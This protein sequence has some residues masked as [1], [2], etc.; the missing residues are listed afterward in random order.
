VDCVLHF[1]AC[2]DKGTR[3]NRLISTCLLALAVLQGVIPADHC[4]LKLAG[5]CCCE[6]KAKKS[7]DAP[8][9][10]HAKKMSESNSHSPDC[11]LHD[12]QRKPC[13]AYTPANGIEAAVQQLPAHDTHSDC[14]TSAYGA[15]AQTSSARATGFVIAPRGHDSPQPFDVPTYL[16]VH[17][18]LI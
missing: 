14:M 5:I 11:P 8:S 9:C 15:D 4:I 1:V 12:N 18:F 3:M 13:C 17:S 10:C 7:D 16:R 2:D 6:A